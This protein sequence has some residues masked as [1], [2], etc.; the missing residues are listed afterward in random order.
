MKAREEEAKAREARRNNIIVFNMPE[1]D[2]NKSSEERLNKDTEDFLKLTKDVCK[3]E[4]KKTDVLQIIRLG[5]RDLE[6][7]RPV[8]IKFKEEDNKKKFSQSIS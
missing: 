3:V 1:Q 4:L 5:K 2:G 6:K 7:K 8:V